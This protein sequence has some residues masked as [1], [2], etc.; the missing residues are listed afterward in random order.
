MTTT[1]IISVIAIVAGPAFGAWLT[2]WLDDRREAHKRK[3][4]IFSALMRTRKMPIHIDHVSALNLIEVEF[5][6]NRNI[7]SAWKS[8]LACLAETL[9]A[10]EEKEKYDAVIKKRDSLLTKLLS[11]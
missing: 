11:E 1:E 2:R 3:F 6:K 4:D 10:V 8:Y 5:I 7:I 9:P